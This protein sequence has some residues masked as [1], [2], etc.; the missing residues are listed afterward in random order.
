MKFFG[1]IVIALL[2]SLVLR[3]QEFSAD[4]KP[5]PKFAKYCLHFKNYVDGLKEFKMLLADDPDNV[6][7]HHGAGI[8]YINLNTD[9]NKALYHLEFV[10]KQEKFDPQAY[11]DLGVAYLQTYR[12][13]DAIKSFEKYLTEV[14]TD[15]NRIPAHRMI[16]V[17]HNA[18]NQVANPVDVEIENLGKLVNSE[19]PDFNPFVPSNESVV[20]FNAQRKT[21]LGNYQFYDGYYPSDI[22]MSVFKFGKWKKSTRLPSAVNST[23]IEKIVGMTSDGLNMF[24]IREDIKGNKQTFFSKKQ[25]K[26]YRDLEPIFIQDVRYEKIHSLTLSPN[27]KYLIF[28][29]NRSDGVGGKDLYMSFRMPNGYWSTAKLLDSIVNTEFDE[30]FPYFSPDGKHFY[31]ASEGHNSMGGYDLYKCLWNY[32][33]ST[34]IKQIYNLGYPINT[35]LDDMT[36]SLSKSGRYGYISSYRDDSYGDLDIYRVVFKYVN[37]TYSVVYGTI[38]DQDSF[39]FLEQVKRW[40]DHI[41]TMNFPIN[42]E[43]KRLLLQKKDSIAAYKVLATKTPYEK[44]D[45]KISAVNMDSGEVF[46]KFRAKD[47]NA[48]YSVILPPGRWKIIFSR[49]G[50][51]DAVIENITIE[52]RDK[53]NK[54]IEMNVKLHPKD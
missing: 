49:K 41:D 36:I 3:G 6:D 12:F 20:I 35:T 54:L 17:V 42:H 52:E 43:Y 15:N 30:D 13:E 19:A 40:N 39:C 2:M 27:N 46:G 24:V 5:D 47:S 28:S 33:D 14:K 11:Y 50:F 38:L 25:G 29:A 8:C 1:F 26:Y 22:Y 7:F 10:V 31:F 37:P 44:V 34:H 23:N 32:S 18:V 48:K 51:Q 16:E 4:Y 45:T 9:K 53:R 21:N